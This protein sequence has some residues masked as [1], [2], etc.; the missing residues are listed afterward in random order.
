[1][2]GVPLSL[3]LSLKRKS[4]TTWIISLAV[5]IL[6]VVLSAAGLIFPDRLYPSEE[7][8]QSFLVNDAINLLFG[9][10]VLLLPMWFTRRGSLFALLCWPGALLYN[11]YNY[12]AY[13]FGMPLSLLTLL[14]VAIV[15]LCAY[16][17]YDLLT[18]VNN[19]AVQVKMEG[20][21]PRRLGG[22]LLVF[23]GAAFFL[24]SVG[25][26]YQ[27]IMGQ[28]TLAMADIGVVIADLVLSIITFT[29]GVLLHRQRASGYTLSVGLLYA[30]SMLFIGLLLI[31][32]VQPLLTATSFVLA[33]F[34]VVAVMT[35]VWLIP[36]GL[37][38]RRAKC[39]TR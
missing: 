37:Y 26:L 36:A 32:A 16:G 11:L 22:W 7:L 10:P 19:L 30:V 35:V 4:T 39:A 21:V 15:I 1:M 27:V 18:G 23:F 33:D 25:L 8:V 5:A 17:F 34:I 24:R 3:E 31:L 38:L 28:Q 2:T 20:A 13:V 14:Y 12:T 29:G 9:L 6:M